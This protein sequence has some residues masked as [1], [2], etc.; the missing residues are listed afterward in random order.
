M[1]VRYGYRTSIFNVALA[2]AFFCLFYLYRQKDEVLGW[3]QLGLA[4]LMLIGAAFFPQRA[5]FRV[6]GDELV[7]PAVLGPIARRYPLREVELRDGRLWARGK[8]LGQAPA[9]WLRADEWQ[10]LCAHLSQVR[11]RGLAEEQAARVS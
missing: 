5:A 4:I 1:R 7:Q 3:V 6:E 11:A 10:A 8:R 9:S 2:V